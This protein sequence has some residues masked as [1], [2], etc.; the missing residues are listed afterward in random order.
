MT[1]SRGLPEAV[2]G[3]WVALYW[4]SLTGGRLAFGLIADRVRTAPAMRVA[5]GMAVAGTA[6]FWWAPTT[7][8][9]GLG[10]VT[11]GAGLAPVFATLIGETPERVGRAHSATAIGVQIAAAGLGGA[12][13]GG[14]AVGLAVSAL[15]L[16]AVGPVL[17]AGAV[18]LAAA[19]EGLA[20]RVRVRAGSR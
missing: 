10:L 16:A 6:L 12:L 13:L 8:M 2:A 5:T 3:A 4:A 9:A 1:L 14:A 7:W 11:T 20:R 15:G 19:Q 17:V 18:G